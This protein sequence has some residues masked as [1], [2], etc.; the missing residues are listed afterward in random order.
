MEQVDES[1]ENEM[2]FA[3]EHI[4]PTHLTINDYE[5]ALAVHQDFEDVRDSSAQNNS[6]QIYQDE[7]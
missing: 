1:E 3:K 6:Y 2:H 4:H 7:A 5:D